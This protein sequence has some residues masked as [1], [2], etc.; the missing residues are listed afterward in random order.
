MVERST[1]GATDAG[2]GGLGWGD[3][4]ATSDED[5]NQLKRRRPTLGASDMN[6]GVPD[7]RPDGVVDTDP[8]L[9][10]SLSSDFCALSERL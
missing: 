4:S 1:D 5:L 3:A 6:E 8:F 9:R 7:V 10:R 2:R